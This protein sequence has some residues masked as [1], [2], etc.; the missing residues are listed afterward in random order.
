MDLVLT[1]D[2]THLALA[3]EKKLKESDIIIQLIPTPRSVSSRCG[4]SLKIE[5]TEIDIIQNTVSE[6][7][8]KYTDIYIKILKEEITYYEK[9]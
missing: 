7:K 5:N 4:F 1:F 9:T 6:K 2:S 3:A 8:I